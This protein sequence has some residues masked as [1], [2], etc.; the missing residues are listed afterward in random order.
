MAAPKKTTVRA[1]RRRKTD[2][3]SSTPTNGAVRSS[4][5]IVNVANRETRIALLED[6]KL[7]EF[8]VEREERVVNA[9][10]RM[11]RGLHE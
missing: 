3:V 5:L 11:E 2:L 10:F 1:P 8:R 4:E 7:M 6:G 9:I